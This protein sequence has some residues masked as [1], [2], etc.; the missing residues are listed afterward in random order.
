LASGVDEGVALL[1][2]WQP[3]AVDLDVNMPD[4]AGFEQRTRWGVVAPAAR[5]VALSAFDK[6]LI[7]RAMT[8][9]GVAAYVSKSGDIREPL[10]AIRTGVTLSP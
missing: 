8:A 4:R 9:A 7:R 3:E 10:D 5:L 2:W 6:T 1:R